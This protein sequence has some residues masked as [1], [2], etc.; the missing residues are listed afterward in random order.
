MSMR[1]MF[2]TNKRFLFYRVKNKIFSQSVVYYIQV[3]IVNAPSM[4]TIDV[5]DSLQKH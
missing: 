1:L 5:L 2:K 4:L 3:N